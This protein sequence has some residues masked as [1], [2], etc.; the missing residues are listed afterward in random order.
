MADIAASIDFESALR[1]LWMQA[2]AGDELAYRDALACIAAH[3]R[4]HLR[5]R[6]QAAPDELE[7]LVQECL[8]AVHL[9]RGSCDPALPVSAWVHA[10][11]RYK[12]VDFLRRRGR[13]EALHDPIDDIDEASLP[14]APRAS[15]GVLRDL[16]RLLGALPEAQRQAIVLT[17]MEGLSIAEASGRT[18]VSGAAIK[19]QVHRGL[20]RLAALI[21]ESP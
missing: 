3:L 20:K 14:S 16:E 18:G 9:H 17:R 7:D 10:I 15:E 4:R 11:A 6:M 2:A 21:R 5:R 19:V 13:R 12:L 1:P 8:L